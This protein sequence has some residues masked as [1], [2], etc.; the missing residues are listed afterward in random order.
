MS[1]SIAETSLTVPNITLVID[2]GYSRVNVYNP[3][4][5]M[6]KLV[7]QRETVF[8]AEQRKGRAGR[9]SNGRCIRLWN[10]KESLLQE[11][12]PEIL[13]SDL[14]NLVL[15]CYAWGAKEINSLNWLDQPQESSWQSAVALLELLGCMKE[16]LITELGKASLL[17]GLNVRE[18]CVALSGILFNK[19][20]LSTSIALEYAEQNIVDK[21]SQ[22]NQRIELKKRCQ[23]FQKNSQIIKCFPQEFTN[24]S[25]EFALLCGFSDRIGIKVDESSS[26]VYKFPS[27]REAKLFS[28][29]LP[30]YIIAI[31][32]DAGDRIGTIYKSVPVEELL[33]V[34]FI[35]QR[36]KIV[37]VTEF[38]EDKT[39]KK[40]K[41][42]CYGKIIL[43]E[44]KIKIEKS[45]YLEAV[46]QEVNKNGVEWLPLSN[47]S[48]NLL[49]RCQF[50]LQNCSKGDSYGN[51]LGDKYLNLKDTVLQWLSPFV[52]DSN[53][54]TEKN[55]FDA[56]CYWLEE[57]RLQNS[58][59]IKVQLANGKT[60]YLDYVIH[61]EKVCIELELIIQQ[62]FGIF[63][64]PKIMGKP[65][66]FKLLS[67]ARR[68]LQITNDLENFWANT[69]P[70]ICK[71]MKGRYPKHNW[72]YRVV[73][74]D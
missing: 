48:K 52:I 72:D 45:D 69:W 15:E 17:L 61:D 46:S 3:R 4:V 10:E 22:E 44:E 31:D 11:L 23:I 38:L 12:K 5:G 1:S 40:F 51:T 21:K 33:V 54:L 41:K 18:A 16:G 67:P 57:L 59:P 60:K 9:V 14:A 32:V 66:L 7:T 64:T 29:F 65:I 30:K 68:P 63:E 27:G 62:A 50:Y 47:E 2:S 37:M 6:Q 20:E 55:V 36:S 53:K 73:Q 58:V 74:K 34:N 42:L 71:E 25:T 39:C 8:N 70:E 19:L 28:E 49:L 24:F 35:E 26:N 43:R 13:R 56:L